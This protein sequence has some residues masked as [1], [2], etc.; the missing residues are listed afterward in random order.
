MQ[1]G[2]WNGVD[3]VGRVTT[4]ED[5]ILTRICMFFKETKQFSFH[6]TQNCRTSNQKINRKEAT[7]LPDRILV[8]CS[9]ICHVPH[10]EVKLGE[11][12]KCGCV[13]LPFSKKM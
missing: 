8:D 6:I 5:E 7:A 3:Y 2:A 10:H 1:A 4:R 13:E 9:R 12:I 11:A